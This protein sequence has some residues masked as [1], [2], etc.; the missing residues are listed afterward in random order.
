MKIK[1]STEK[2]KLVEN[3]VFIDGLTRTGKFFLGKLISSFNNMEYFQYQFIMDYIVYMAR[4]GSITEDGII[5][6]LRGVIDQ[7]SYDRAI[8]RNLNLRSGDRSSLKNSWNLESY[9]SRASGDV[10]RKKIVENL[11]RNSYSYPYVTHNNLSNARILIKAFPKLKM[12]HLI[13]NPIDLV[14][15]WSQKGYGIKKIKNRLDV[16]KVGLNP[17]ISGRSGPVPWYAVYID[18][19]YIK[20]NQMDRIIISIITLMKLC[21]KEY[22]K[23]NKKQKSRIMFVKYESLVENTYE[24]MDNIGDFLKKTKN[25]D[26]KRIINLE[27]CPNVIDI[28]KRLEKDKTVRSKSTKYYYKM[29]ESYSRNYEKNLIYN[30]DD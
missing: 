19:N 7:S 29:L 26:Y 3:V 23:L 13:R 5:S 12:I 24:E 22:N 11:S 14:Y 6:L 2:I 8:G 4:L 18:D 30:T 15:S 21:I 20:L 17:S 10:D 25:D 16:F 28:E 27:N 9:L 1:F